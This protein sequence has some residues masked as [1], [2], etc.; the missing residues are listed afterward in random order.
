MAEGQLNRLGYELLREKRTTDAIE[1]FKLNAEAFASSANVHDSLAEAY[2]EAGMKD[3]AIKS[4]AKALEL[5]PG[6]RNTITK[7]NDLVK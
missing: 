5:D 2:A 4:Y 3:L 6:N 1:I 7:L